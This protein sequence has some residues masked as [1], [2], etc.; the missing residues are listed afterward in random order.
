VNGSSD[1]IY[2]VL[3]SSVPEIAPKID[4]AEN[5][6]RW[7]YTPLFECLFYNSKDNNF[8]DAFERVLAKGGIYKRVMI[9]MS[10]SIYTASYS[11]QSNNIEELIKVMGPYTPFQYLPRSF[12]L[13]KKAAENSPGMLVK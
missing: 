6:A 8:A 7:G 5:K 1:D 9:D 11:E 3:M 10:G 2:K 13:L 12:R 4:I